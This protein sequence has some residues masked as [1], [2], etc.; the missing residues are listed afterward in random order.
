[1]GYQEYY[2]LGLA[3]VCVNLL[4][5]VSFAQNNMPWKFIYLFILITC[6]GA[7]VPSSGEISIFLSWILAVTVKFRVKINLTY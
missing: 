3:C 5:N 2:I 4:L 7:D 1:M 6:L